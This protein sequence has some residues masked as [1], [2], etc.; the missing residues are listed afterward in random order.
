VHESFQEKDMAVRQSPSVRARQ[1]ARELRG[2]RTRAG[3]TIDQVAAEMKWSTA[4]VSRIETAYTLITVADLHR[5]L[6]F[7]GV[8]EPA[9]E[10][11][12]RLARAAR[13]RGWWETYGETLGE[14]Y[15][16]FIGL[17]ADAQA[18]HSYRVAIIHGLLQTADYTRACMMASVPALPPGEVDRQVEIRL[19]RQARLRSL[20]AMELFAVL[21]EGALRRR[22]ADDGVMRNQ[23]EYLL[24]AGK[25]SNVR[26]LVVP[27]DNGY[28]GGLTDFSVLKFQEPE[29]PDIVYIEQMG[30]SLIIED[31]SQVFR[32]TS[33]FE[34]I[35][36]NALDETG[37]RDLIARIA[38]AY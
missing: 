13:E 10:R 18:M 7:Y 34:K 35:C 12:V 29:Y 17:E 37:S 8:E 26:I 14:R 31:E 25:L 2:L 16:A 4:K 27:F 30:G 32:Y 6:A 36:G 33:A 21:D 23:L 28:P 3:V 11:Y 24:E 19:K 9:V 38:R 22:I 1:L 5:L 20:E 15:A